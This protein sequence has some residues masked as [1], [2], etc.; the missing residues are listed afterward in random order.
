ME[1]LPYLGG[2][3]AVM[4]VVLLILAT[5]SKARKRSKLV[6][7][8]GM[9]FVPG[10]GVAEKEALEGKAGL[11]AK[12]GVESDKYWEDEI[13]PMDLETTKQSEIGGFDDI[14]VREGKLEQSTDVMEESSSIEEL[15]GLPPQST[16][17]DL[18][19]S[20]ESLADLE[21]P[22]S[23]P[24]PE[25]GLPE[26]WTMEQWKWYGAEWLSRQK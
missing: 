11:S 17:E 23:P 3:F 8:Y 5:V 4:I 21:E 20:N 24:I 18:A 12:G 6:K 16:A 19:T 10:E 7:Q 13:E 1:I 15:A 2:G 26:G 14:D 25:S 9:P 22:V